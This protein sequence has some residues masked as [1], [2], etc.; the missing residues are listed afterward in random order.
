MKNFLNY[1]KSNEGS[2]TIVIYIT[3]CTLLVRKGLKVLQFSLKGPEMFNDI[4]VM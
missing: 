4:W 1:M 3:I 2:T